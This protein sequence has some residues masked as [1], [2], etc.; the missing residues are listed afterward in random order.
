MQKLLWI[1]WYT[2]FIVIVICTAHGKTC[3]AAAKLTADQIFVVVRGLQA[4]ESVGGSVLVLLVKVVES[5]TRAGGPQTR[6][7]STTLPSWWFSWK[8]CHFVGR[9]FDFVIILTTFF[10]LLSVATVRPASE[11]ASSMDGWRDG[12]SGCFTPPAQKF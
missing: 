8:N 11:E 12:F 10:K 4:R 6:I 9:F 5:Q 1:G 7:M 2:N 3:R